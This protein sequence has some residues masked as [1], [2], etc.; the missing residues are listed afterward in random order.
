MVMR[1][2]LSLLIVFATVITAAAE[3][4]SALSV[5]ADS[6]ILIEASS[7]RVIYEKNADMRCPM[8]STTKIM[9][10]IVAIEDGDTTREVSVS[11]EAVGVEGSSVYLK[12]GDVIT[13]DDLLWA[14]MLESANDA[15]AAIAVEVAGSVEAFADR[16]NMK[17]AE[18]GLSDTNFTNPHGLDNEAHY[19]T[20]RD[21]VRL[22]AYAMKNAKFRE[23]AS[24]YRHSIKVGDETRCLL[25][26]N[27][28]LKLYDGAVGVKTGYTKRSGRCLV[29]AAERDGVE[30]VAV[31]LNAPDDW[32]DH[33]AM[34]DH[35]F[36]LLEA[37]ELI[38]PGE[39]VFILPCIGCEK[40]EV[41]VKNTEG[42]TLCLPKGAEVEW[43][44]ELPHYLWA[45]I[46]EGER[47]GRIVFSS[48]GS[49][50]GEVEL[51]ADEAAERISVKSGILGLFG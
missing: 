12:G 51:F 33:T 42:L 8:A 22:S 40:N 19:T 16:M 26:H 34:L 46:T 45:E 48:S 38:K 13:L 1:N 32:N 35:G 31:T 29:S 9:T 36:G 10:A 5:S 11:S 15:A 2:W 39:S 14:L 7:G 30:L 50:I 27:K 47:V 44:V 41:R 17:A 18:L 4:I 21:L 28:L 24:T 23:I 6:A 43:T 37:R 20:A 49:V 3:P 25:N